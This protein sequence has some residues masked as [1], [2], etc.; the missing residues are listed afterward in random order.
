M[1]IHPSVF[2]NTLQIKSCSIQFNSENE[3][4]FNE[5]IHTLEKEEYLIK[6]VIQSV[7]TFSGISEETLLTSSDEDFL[8]FQSTF[9]NIYA[10]IFTLNI[11]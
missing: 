9:I 2:G 1:G 6:I 4:K 3:E 10:Y 8:K 7:Q 5:S 11:G